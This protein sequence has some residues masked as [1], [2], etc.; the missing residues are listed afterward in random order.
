M[1]GTKHNA[2]GNVQKYKFVMDSHNY[3]LYII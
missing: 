2:K 1:I 3:G